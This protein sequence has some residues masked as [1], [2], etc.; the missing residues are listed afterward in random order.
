LWIPQ[1]EQQDGTSPSVDI[2]LI[3]AV[4]GRII[5]GTAGLPDFAMAPNLIAV[6][7]NLSSEVTPLVALGI[8]SLIIILI[9]VLIWCFKIG[10]SEE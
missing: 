5:F 9:A 1:R 6:W 10:E 7:P 2:D 3:N 8:D 4:F